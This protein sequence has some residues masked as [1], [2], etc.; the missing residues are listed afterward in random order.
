M[1]AATYPLRIQPEGKTL[2]LKRDLSSPQN[3]LKTL[4]IARL[5]RELGLV[6][7]WGSGV[8]RIFAE[9]QQQGLP[10]SSLTE[11]AIRVRMS[12]PLA[13]RHSVGAH[14]AEPEAEATTTPAVAACWSKA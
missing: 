5:F 11:I 13:Q 3:T 2:E 6:E 7:Q 10:Q 8:L 14:A 4:V 9:A 1:T 12:I